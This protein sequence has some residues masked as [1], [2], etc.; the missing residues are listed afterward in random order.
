MDTRKLL[1]LGLLQKN[2]SESSEY[3]YTTVDTGDMD[4]LRILDD[5]EDI[6]RYPADISEFKKK[7]IIIHDPSFALKLHE[8]VSNDSKLPGFYQAKIRMWTDLLEQGFTIRVYTKAGLKQVKNPSE[9]EAALHE[10]LPISRHD[11]SKYLGDAGYASKDC[12]LAGM[13]ET[14]A[15][16]EREPIIQLDALRALPDTI[17]DKFLDSLFDSSPV[18]VKFSNKDLESHTE[19]LRKFKPPIYFNY[20]EIDEKDEQKVNKL[21][22]DSLLAFAPLCKKIK[23]ADNR[24]ITWEDMA[25]IAEASLH[26]TILKNPSEMKGIIP[27]NFPILHSLKKIKM[28]C[29]SLEML[30]A[31]FSFL[32]KCPSIESISLRQPL[33]SKTTNACNFS[34]ILPTSLSKLKKFK[35]FHRRPGNNFENLSWLMK[36]YP[37][38]ETVNLQLNWSN[39]VEDFQKYLFSSNTLK[40]IS[41][42]DTMWKGD[43]EDRFISELLKSCP[44]LEEINLERLSAYVENYD[45]EPPAISF[46]PSNIKKINVNPVSWDTSPWELAL[47]VL[48]NSASLEAMTIHNRAT[49]SINMKQMPEDYS[50]IEFPL[51]KNLRFA[52][53]I[54]VSWMDILKFLKL[55]PSAEEI[56][57]SD[58]CLLDYELKD[59]PPEFSLPSIKKLGFSRCEISK[60]LFPLLKIFPSL[61]EVSLQDCH[62]NTLSPADTSCVFPSIKKI[63]LSNSRLKAGITWEFISEILKMCPSAEELDLTNRSFQN[64]S[65]PKDLSFLANLKFIRLDAIEMHNYNSHSL[66]NTLYQKIKSAYP[67]I[68]V[69]IGGV[70]NIPESKYSSSDTKI[71]TEEIDER[72]FPSPL[73]FPIHPA[74][75]DSHEKMLD[76]IFNEK[77]IKL[78]ARQIFEGIDPHFYRCAS[79]D[80]ISLDQ[81]SCTLKK[82][83]FKPMP[84]DLSQPSRFATSYP[85]RFIITASDVEN[86]EWIPLP[87]LTVADRLTAILTHPEIK[88]TLAYNDKDKFY[89]IQ[90][91]KPLKDSPF[92]VSFTIESFLSPTKRVPVGKFNDEYYEQISNLTFNSEGK[93]EKNAAFDFFSA[94]SPD[95]QLSALTWYFRQ[96]SRKEV[97]AS[98]EERGIALVNHIIRYNPGGCRHRCMAFMAL[99]REFNL[100]T[101][102]I[103][104]DIH[105]YVE[106]TLNGQREKA[107][108]GGRRAQVEKIPPPKVPEVS[109]T[110]SASSQIDAA[111][112][113]AKH[114][115]TTTSITKTARPIPVQ[116]LPDNP[117]RTWDTIAIEADSMQTYVEK[118]LA[119]AD[120]LDDGKKNALC[121]MNEDEL[122]NFSTALLQLKKKNCYYLA[123]LN[124]VKNKQTIVDNDTGKLGKDDSVL[125]KFLENAQS[126]DVLLVDWSHYE[127]KH[128]GYNSIMDAKRRMM[129]MEIPAG[130]TVIGVINRGQ[131][132]GEDFYSRF[133]MVSEC[134]ANLP[135][136]SLLPNPEVI[137]DKNGYKEIRFY[138]DAW[139][140]LLRKL[141]AENGRF[142]LHEGKL[143]KAILKNKEGVILRNAPWEL[144]EFRH[145]II[146]LQATRELE[147][148][149]KTYA[150]PNTFKILRDDTPYSLEGKYSVSAYRQDMSLETAYVINP[151]TLNSLFQQV[152]ANEDQINTLSGIMADHKDKDL[153]L[154][155]THDLSPL[156]WARIIHT[157]N[158]KSVS[159]NFILG[160]GIKMPAH[161]QII[162][163]NKLPQRTVNVIETNDID[164]VT[165][166]MPED[167]IIIPVNEKT[168]YSDLI[169]SQRVRRDE[170]NINCQYNPGILLKALQ[171]GKKVILKGK[172]SNAL[173]QALSPVFLGYLPANGK[174]QENLQG[175]LTII[176]DKNPELS[177]VEHQKITVNEDNIWTRLGS[178][179]GEQAEKLQDACKEFYQ[180]S[181][182]PPFSYI[183]LQSMLSHLNEHP[184]SNPFK[185]LL[186]ARTNYLMLKPIVEDSWE[187]HRPRKKE[188]ASFPILEKRQN[189][190]AERVENN[191]YVFVTGLSGVGKTTTIQQAIHALGYEPVQTSGTIKEKLKAWV[192]PG[193]KRALFID[194]ANLYE[195]GELDILE[196]L[197]KTPPTLLIDDVEYPVPPDNRLFF[198]GNFAHFKGRQELRF[199]RRHGNVITFK[200]FDDAFLKDHIM[201]PICDAFKLDS[202]Q[203]EDV[204][205][206]FLNLYHY[207]NA[208]YPDKHPLT[209][210]N[211]QMMI[212]RFAIGGNACLAAY[213]EASGVL[214][215]KGRKDVALWIN[216]TYGDDIKLLKQRA[217]DAIP[218][219]LTS[220][221]VI[222]KSRVN[223]VR[224]LENH[225]RIR[226][227]KIKKGDTLAGT[228]SSGLILEGNPGIG[229]SL[230]PIEYLS[231]QGF[232]N[233]DEISREE[234]VRAGRDPSKRYYY[235]QAG[236]IDDIK[237]TL[238]KAFHEGAWVIID[239]MNTLPLENLLNAL[240]SGA[241]PEGVKAEHPGFFV[242]GTQ[243]PIHYSHRSA[244][245]DA[246]LNRFQKLDL[247]EYSE[248][249]LKAITTTML[250]DNQ[251]ANELVDYFLDAQSYAKQHRKFPSPS[252]RDL[253][254]KTK[255]IASDPDHKKR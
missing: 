148:N 44:R 220:G 81:N 121:V 139:R 206:I 143:L 106:V 217:K 29:N 210:R 150:L 241:T 145:F 189:K 95:R 136:E 197:Y 200:E 153:S 79:Y 2:P 160:P 157:A 131:M 90:P 223:P 11:L 156:Q 52:G 199:V 218:Q 19:F 34:D 47:V 185:Q 48:K 122:S 10:V 138:D 135:A 42:F 87:S 56:S 211:L 132:M 114:E 219:E 174:R 54:Q 137:V 176:T 163:Q 8:M 224:I 133:R 215:Q 7:N 141:N 179:Y 171:D 202:Q 142:T 225:M 88:F 192:E 91:E 124:A 71:H 235:I 102:M 39:V 51:L 100:P 216:R 105:S 180:A 110:V 155:I 208:R 237:K 209:A 170:E 72:I 6:Y 4:A 203:A 152:H 107:D 213:D 196:G 128:V 154:F 18:G 195:E 134:P 125:K 108:L 186:R 147:V 240:L 247:K 252:Q 191:W 244:Y 78:Q 62:L 9:L 89:Y 144:P 27:D 60:E 76:S 20:E 57:F 31:N 255:T 222:T 169:G 151:M 13:A 162:S 177:F 84:C 65:L 82:A 236:E 61:E 184:L 212:M 70:L 234:A 167:A 96:P 187:I 161:P 173:S 83:P 214:N 15:L 175:E 46:A 109:A 207:V 130:V 140:S 231:S 126:G 41:L 228:G 64:Y 229:K 103:N 112:L 98:R 168:T 80:D 74:A 40:K 146:A 28:S 50:P 24:K 120:Q 33:I 129:G 94:L 17:C 26:L 58:G 127:A 181:Y 190:L 113:F 115:T 166:T 5:K 204:K 32:E 198:S 238:I 101:E 253:F 248:A 53:T 243:N 242:T 1:V 67:H 182:E 43:F 233:G 55:C 49:Q 111:Q 254:E 117:F 16:L 85:G 194:E 21:K 86:N 66:Q 37:L 30:N 93:L 104:N 172:L 221:F 149:G 59:L 75:T 226:D 22:I 193:A 230:L 245:S 38:L 23:F 92:T 227:E 165:S 69:S 68:I 178:E 63:N 77:N 205:E 119:S 158:E 73:D 36:T 12:Y 249:E 159:V 188:K 99:A 183:E 97:P 116:L 246:F 35:M 239:E 123:D 164:Y 232:V 118:L 251:K 3:H 14:S 25:K 201:Q 250:A 45:A